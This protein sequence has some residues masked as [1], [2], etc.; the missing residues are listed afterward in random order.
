[1]AGKGRT[2]WFMMAMLLIMVLP[3]PPA[4]LD[5][6]ASPSHVAYASD[7]VADFSQTVSGGAEVVSIGHDGDHY[8]VAVS[9][10]GAGSL[11]SY[12]WVGSTPGGLLLKVAHNG[13]VMGSANQPYAPLEMAVSSDFIALIGLHP[14]EG[15]F[16]EAYHTNMNLAFQRHI[17]ST[18][19]RE[20]E[21]TSSSTILT[22]T[23]PK[24]TFWSAARQRVL[25]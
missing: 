2:A 14:S 15:L 4:V 11:G 24:P 20:T 17:Y 16:M 23:E 10:N 19:R 21:T 8:F 25:N 22:L 13:T 12:T 7:M 9:H 1:M 6:E 5:E 3:Q 18:T